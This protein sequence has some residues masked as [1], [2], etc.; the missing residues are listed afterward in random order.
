MPSKLDA[1]SVR[2]SLKKLPE[3]ELDGDAITRAYEFE[4]FVSGIEFVN[5]VADIAEE[6]HHHP[7]ISIRYTSVTLSLTTHDKGGLTASD[8]ELAGRIDHLFD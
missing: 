2:S 8:F 3:W 7:D 1:E 4:D 6:A 5:T